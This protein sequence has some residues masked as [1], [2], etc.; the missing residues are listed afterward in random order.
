MDLT[1]SEDQKLIQETARDFLEG[2]CPSDHVREMEGDPRG[3]SPELWREM[4][5]LGWMGAA[6]PEEHGGSGYGFLD[7]C[8]LIEEQGRVRLPSPFLSTVVLC[9]LAV[10]R[11]GSDEQ[12]AEHLPAI[13]AG[14]RVL[15]W[16]ETDP[17]TA[18]W[19]EP[20][21]AA[22]DGDGFV[23][24][25]VKLFVPYAGAADHL[26][27]AARTGGGS[28]EERVLLLVDA[29]ADGVTSERLGTIDSGHACRVT[30]QEVAVPGGS[31]LVPPTEGA[32]AV[33][34]I[35]Q[36]GAVATSAEMLG[37][38]QKVLEMSLE[39]ARQREQ[40]GRPIGTFQAVQHHCADMA[41][42]VAGS[43]FITYE[44]AWRLGEDL[45]AAEVVSAAKAWVSDAYQRVC[46]RGHQIHGAIGFTEEETLQLYTRH[47][48]A[49]EQAFGD[50]DHHRERVARQLGL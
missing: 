40:F 15:A 25:G 6:F 32:D 37:G 43:R 17:V 13:A 31:V 42:D 12:K 36:W 47:A 21:T 3:Y 33:R 23:L 50:G 30:F 35:R 46:Q 26:L 41:V 38:A 8:L 18:E 2:A 10:E 49:A 29:G 1:L 44:A 45:D 14:E 4:A 22:A 24:D 19:G 5:E 48:K 34:T 11:F 27:V 7:L 9:G 16:A 20:A 39:Y 28:D